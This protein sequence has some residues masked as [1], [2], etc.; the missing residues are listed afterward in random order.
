[1]GTIIYKKFIRGHSTISA[2]NITQPAHDP[3]FQIHTTISEMG[4]ELQ[5]KKRRSGLPKI[6]QRPKSIKTI[7]KDPIIAA[8]W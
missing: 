4:R 7:V 6:K 2:I 5:K 1:M 3:I 8:H